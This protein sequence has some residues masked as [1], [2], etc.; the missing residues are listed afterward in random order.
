MLVLQL[1]D[2]QKLLTLLS[3]SFFFSFQFVFFCFFCCFFSVLFF[4]IFVSM[5]Q[6][7][8]KEGYMHTLV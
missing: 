5:L 2:L 6:L 8:R 3:V 7:L 1:P 4:R